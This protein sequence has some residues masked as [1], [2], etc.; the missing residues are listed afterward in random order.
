AVKLRSD[1]LPARV[2]LGQLTLQQREFGKANQ[3]AQEILALDAN[4]A[5]AHL[6]RSRALLGMGQVKQAR[7]EL[8]QTAEQFPQLSEARLHIAG[9]DLQERNF[10]AAEDGFRKLLAERRDPRAFLGLMDS[11]IG[12]G[13][14][15]TAKK[16]LKEEIARHPERMEYRFAMAALNTRTNDLNGAMLDYKSIL[17][18][19]P[20]NATAWL[21]I[22]DLHRRTGDLGASIEAGRKAQELAPNTVSPHLQLALL[23]EGAGKRIEARPM[24][25]QVLKLQPSNVIALN[26]LAYILAE[27]GT[28]LDQALTMAQQA[29]QMFPNDLNI[30]DTLGWIYIK[31][32]LPDS[33]ISILRDI[34][35]KQPQRATYHYHLAMALF[36]KGDRASAKKSCEVALSQKPSKAEEDQIRELMSKI[37]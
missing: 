3:M 14:V 6:L 1:Y 4:H 22:S 25:E 8:T 29:R 12:Q 10:K 36:Q 28:D 21:R 34:I 17:A 13:Q 31:K 18:A 2:A 15:D 23:Y 32:N 27:N 16:L 19:D 26:N 20:K 11:Y 35:Q 24:Y 5:G 37:G 7:A 9:L 30:A 33:A